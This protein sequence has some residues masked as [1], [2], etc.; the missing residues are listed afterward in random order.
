MAI[1]KLSIF[2]DTQLFFPSLRY[3][4]RSEL[5]RHGDIF[6]SLLGNAKEIFKVL[7]FSHLPVMYKSSNCSIL[8]LIPIIVC[9][10]VVSHWGFALVSCDFNWLLL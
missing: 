2:L 8:W 4:T 7:N 6:I 3:I 5:L 10:L 1:F 9:L